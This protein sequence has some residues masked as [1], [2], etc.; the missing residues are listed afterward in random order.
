MQTEP[1]FNDFETPGW[2]RADAD[3]TRHWVHVY[4][5]SEVLNE[6]N[7][8]ALVFATKDGGRKVCDLRVPPDAIYEL[9]DWVDDWLERVAA[10]RNACDGNL[11]PQSIDLTFKRAPNLSTPQWCDAVL[12][13]EVGTGRE[14]R[15]VVACKVESGVERF[16]EMTV[17]VRVDAK[18]T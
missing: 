6:F 9:L 5:T 10:E 3:S 8:A 18:T 1:N 4:R 7:Q 12:P 15:N 11:K 2:E 16:T 17:V 14:L 13:I